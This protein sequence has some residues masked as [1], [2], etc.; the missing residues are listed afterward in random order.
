MREVKALFRP[1]R[2]DHVIEALREV[3]GLPGVT[4][5]RVDHGHGSGRGPARPTT[6]S[7]D[8]ALALTSRSE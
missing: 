6:T 5:S 8:S 7:L 4:V 1:Q 2:L 3:S